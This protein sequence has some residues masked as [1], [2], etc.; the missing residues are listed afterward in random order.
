MNKVTTINLSGRA[1]QVEEQAYEKL[2]KY[3]ESARRKLADDPDQQEVMQDFEQ[4]LAD[5]CEELLSKHKN[6]VTAAEVKKIIAAMGPVEVDENDTKTHETASEATSQA[7]S[8]RLY[9]LKDGA[10]IGG[11]CNG[12]AAYFNIDVTIVRLLFVVLTFVTSGFMVL[13]YLIMM[14]VVPEAVTPEQK[15]ELRGERFTA[16]DV[17]SRAK[18]K[19]SEVRKDLSDK[20][21]WHKVGKDSAPALQAAGAVTLKA[22]RIIFGIAAAAFAIMVAA[23]TCGW[24]A[25]MWWLFVGH[26]HFAD[27]LHTIPIWVIAVA[28]S[29]AYLISMLPFAV[30]TS[31]FVRLA[32]NKQAAKRDIQT[33]I[34]AAALWILS[35][36]ALLGVGIVCQS[37]VADYQR[38]HAYIEFDHH[39][40]CINDNL[41]DPGW[42][43]EDGPIHIK[44]KQ[45]HE[46]P[47]VPIEPSTL[48][49][50]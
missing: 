10:I 32:R 43:T 29:A 42:Q 3:L 16:Q 18:Q 38:T 20:E 26:P 25:L 15:A 49:T 46:T 27:Q 39:N 6:V 30:L 17:I 23:L 35:C 14:L 22:A 47:A 7:A 21:H 2:Q 48:F 11:V 13:V 31:I 1:F 36:G 5:K 19:Y 45:L 8:K 44:G 34:T 33:Y 24:I 40:F 9:L 28:G 12:L 50:N 4:A 41:C 37:R